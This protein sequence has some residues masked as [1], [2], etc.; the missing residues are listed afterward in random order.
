MGR[1]AVGL[2]GFFFL[3]SACSIKGTHYWSW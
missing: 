1:K 2:W 3:N